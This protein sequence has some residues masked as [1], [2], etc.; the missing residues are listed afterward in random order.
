MTLVARAVE[1]VVI[2]TSEK[3]TALSL[4]A[5][6]AAGVRTRGGYEF[7]GSPRPGDMDAGE[8]KLHLEA[9]I[10]I[11]V[12]QHVPETSSTDP[13]WNATGDLGTLHATCAIA[14]SI[15]AG[16]I[17]PADS[18]NLLAHGLD[19]EA[20]R[21]GPSA[22][23][24]AY[25][26]NGCRIRFAHR[27]RP[28]VYLGFCCGLTAAMCDALLDDPLC[29]DPLFWIDFASLAQRPSPK[30][31][32]AM[33]QQAQTKIG[34]V[35]VDRDTVIIDGVIYGLADVDLNVEPVDPRATTIPVPD[36]A[37]FETE[38]PPPASTKPELPNS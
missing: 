15:R 11:F 34:N 37:H 32:I 19:M 1:A 18:T 20:I 30:R 22:D 33:H 38:P 23:S 21:N 27:Y 28:L 5:L 13:S 12:T 2:D 25:A 9:D 17:T 10:T 26:Q 24:F 8:L 3:Q 31:N 29:G 4:A 36:G 7:F 6:W 16:Y 14:N 35:D